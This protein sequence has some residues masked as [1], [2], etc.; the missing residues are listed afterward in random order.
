MQLLPLASLSIYRA[1]SKNQVYTKSYKTSQ[2][3]ILRMQPNESINVRQVIKL[4]LTDTQLRGKMS[5]MESR[6]YIDIELS[7]TTCLMTV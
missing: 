2:L 3:R 5:E 1:H 7:T 6:K 4:N